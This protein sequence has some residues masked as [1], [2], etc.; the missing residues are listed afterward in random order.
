L[1]RRKRRYSIT[2]RH[3]YTVALETGFLKAID[4]DAGNILNERVYDREVIS[5]SGA[6][7]RRL[8]E[9]FATLVH[10]NPKKSE[11]A[12]EFFKQAVADP[13]SVLDPNIDY[14]REYVE[15]FKL[16]HPAEWRKAVAQVEV[17]EE[18]ADEV[19]AIGAEELLRQGVMLDISEQIRLG[20]FKGHTSAK[21]IFCGTVTEN[22]S[23]LWAGWM[24]DFSWEWLRSEHEFIVGDDPLSR[25]SKRLKHIEYGFNHRDCEVT[26]PLSRHLCLRMH[27]DG[28]PTEAVKKCDCQTTS[29]YNNRQIL[30]ATK[31]IFGSSRQMLNEKQR[32]DDIAAGRCRLPRGG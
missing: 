9:W 4:S 32:W 6:E 29:K 25:W 1:N 21:D 7:R 14:A 10:R 26:I 19:Q 23:Q 2:E 15:R 12:K 8:A 24:L 28:L 17:A 30:A 27:R 3:L 18:L 13:W 11:S 20:T 16:E 22:R 31:K 5:L